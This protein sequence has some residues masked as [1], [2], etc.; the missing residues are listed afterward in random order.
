MF[1]YKVSRE[2]FIDIL[3]NGLIIPKSALIDRADDALAFY[4]SALAEYVN[5]ADNDFWATLIEEDQIIISFGDKDYLKLLGCEDRMLILTFDN[6]YFDPNNASHEEA[7]NIGHVVLGLITFNDI[8]RKANNEFVTWQAE[9]NEDEKNI[10]EIKDNKKFE[11]DSLEKYSNK[12]CHNKL[13][14]KAYKK[15]TIKEFYKI[16][17]KFNL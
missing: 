6:G 8:W 4:F 12:S 5:D 3:V 15:M 2:E 9:I 10:Y 17:D 1:N 11:F 7:Q 13:D 14:K 16:Y